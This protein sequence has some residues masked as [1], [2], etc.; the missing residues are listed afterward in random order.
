MNKEKD[1][2]CY[3]SV[4]DKSFQYGDKNS[5]VF[6]DSIW[7]QLVEHYNLTEHEQRAA[8]EFIK[9]RCAKLSNRNA[10]TFICIDCAEKALQRRLLLTDVADCPFNQ[11]FLA[12]YLNL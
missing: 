10:H 2:T 7:R 8:E 9:L 3:C 6:I 12:E 4:C 5:P 1:L 11:A